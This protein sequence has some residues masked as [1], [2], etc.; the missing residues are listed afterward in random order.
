MGRF[1]WPLVV[2]ASCTV[3]LA[4]CAEE[5]IE[6]TEYYVE[7]PVYEITYYEVYYDPFYIS[8]CWGVYYY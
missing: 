1:S 2:L 7:E 4:G 5:V 3:F 6:T 8:P